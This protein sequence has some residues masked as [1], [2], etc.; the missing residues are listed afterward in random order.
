MVVPWDKDLNVKPIGPSDI[1]VWMDL[2]AI[3]P[4]LEIHASFLLKQV[5]RLVFSSTSTSLSKFANIRGCVLL[6]QEKPFPGLVHVDVAGEGSVQMEIA[7]RS[8]P[9]T[10][11]FCNKKATLRSFVSVEEGSRKALSSELS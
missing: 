6:N 9:F 3:D 11:R 1:P 4:L 5:G 2:M 7:Y 8:L 10:C